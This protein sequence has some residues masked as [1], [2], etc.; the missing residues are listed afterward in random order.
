MRR[1]QKI[2]ETFN[3]GYL[4]FGYDTILRNDNKKRIGETFEEK[5]KL[6]FTELSARD[7]DYNFAYMNNASLDLKV[8]TLYPPFFREVKKSKLKCLIDG[9]K[10]DVLKVDAD[11]DKRYL[12]FYLQNVGAANE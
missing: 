6:A 11:K 3:D 2:N 9:I 1:Q 4:Y 12:Y 10:Y 5:G 7:Q 8:K